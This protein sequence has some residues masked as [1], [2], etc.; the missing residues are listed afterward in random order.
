[1]SRRWD[2]QKITTKMLLEE[3]A[4]KKDE[5]AEVTPRFQGAES[6]EERN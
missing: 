3:E 5:E 1:M 4:R 6:E 2:Q